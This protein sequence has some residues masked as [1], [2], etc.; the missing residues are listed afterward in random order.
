[1]RVQ[2]LS[3]AVAS[4]GCW[5]CLVFLDS[6]FMPVWTLL[7]L[8]FTA[9]AVAMAVSCHHWQPCSLQREEWAPLCQWGLG[10]HK[11][12]LHLQLPSL[13]AGCW[14]CL[15]FLASPTLSREESGC[16]SA[17]GDWAYMR[18]D[19]TCRCHNW[20][21]PA[22]EAGCWQSLAFLASTILSRWEN[23]CLFTSGTGLT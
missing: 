3:L 7:I 15:A 21:L 12:S 1:M 22:L 17:S 2:L 18:A 11:G 14:Q 16:L 4:V 20:H 13:A 23:G 10:L 19:C 5:Q 6:P 8:G 9:S